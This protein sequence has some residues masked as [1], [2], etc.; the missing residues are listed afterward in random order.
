MTIVKNK[1]QVFIVIEPPIRWPI[2]FDGEIFDSVELAPISDQLKRDAFELAEYFKTHTDFD[3]KY[4]A[5]FWPDKEYIEI[6]NQKSIALTKELANELGSNYVINGLLASNSRRG[7]N[8]FSRIKFK[9][10]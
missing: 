6:F 1:K 9:G 7:L 4:D 8:K 3:S 2:W 10:K 5:Y